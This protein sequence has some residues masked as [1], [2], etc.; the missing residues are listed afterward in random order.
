MTRY[1]YRA[2]VIGAD[3]HVVD[4]YDLFCASQDEARDRAKQLVDG[5][6]IELW[7]GAQKIATFRHTEPMSR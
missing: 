6:D 4:R 7:R 1:E 3:G 5:Q 2:F